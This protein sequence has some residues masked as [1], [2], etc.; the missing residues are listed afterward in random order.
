[1][2]LEAFSVSLP[3]LA[4]IMTPAP[5]GPPSSCISFHTPPFTRPWRRLMPGETR[6][7]KS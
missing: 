2:H 1:M 3:P 6:M 7:T 4:V 5:K